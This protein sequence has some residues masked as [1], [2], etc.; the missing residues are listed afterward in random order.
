M[1]AARARAATSWSD[2]EGDA[3]PNDAAESSPPSA[4]SDRFA[5]AESAMP[6]DEPLRARLGRKRLP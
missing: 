2:P 6:H 5:Q 3:L 1:A 4:V